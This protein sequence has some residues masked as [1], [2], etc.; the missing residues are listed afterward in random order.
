M[1]EAFTHDEPRTSRVVQ[2]GNDGE[3]VPARYFCNIK[4]GI[5]AIA[6]GAHVG[7]MVYLCDHFSVE[8][9]YGW[10]LS[11]VVDD[12]NFRATAGLNWHK[13]GGSNLMAGIAFSNAYFIESTNNSH[14]EQW[15]L[16]AAVGSHITNEG[17]VQFYYRGGV[18][19]E[20]KYDSGGGIRYTQ[21]WPNI[22][23]GLSINIF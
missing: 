20:A 13:G 10:P 18:V 8:A 3:T 1:S 14:V 12:W 19:L 4:A 11:N 23:V 2:P 7:T 9:S 16:S 21:I 6:R 5:D 15:F 22:D 17:G